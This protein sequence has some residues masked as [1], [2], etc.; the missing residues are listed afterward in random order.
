MPSELSWVDFSAEDRNSMLDVINLFKEQ[1][2]RDELGIGSIRDAFSDYFFP[3]TSTIQTRAKYMLFV[4]W[5]YKKLESSRV[6][7]SKI[8]KRARDEEIYL[9]Q[10]LKKNNQLD[11]LIGI[12]A[13][14][15][16]KRLPSNIYWSGLG[17]W[18]I[19]TFPANQENYHNYLTTYYQ[20]KSEIK[21]VH[22]E[23]D[24]TEHI[25][26]NWHPGMPTCP[27]G[28]PGNADFTL[29][30]EEA[31]YLRERIVTKHRTSLLAHLVFEK[32]IADVEHIWEYPVIK[33]ATEKLQAETIL[34]R[35]FSEAI[36]GAALLYNYMLADMKEDND[37]KEDFKNRLS[38]WSVL[39]SDRFDVFKNWASNM[40]K[41][42]SSEPLKYARIPERTKIFVEDWSKITI[43]ERKYKSLIDDSTTKNLIRNREFRLKRSRARLDN[44]RALELWS[45]DS[46]TSILDYRWRT[47]RTIVSDIVAG[48]NNT[49]ERH[50]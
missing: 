19:R 10:I 30:T 49:G 13:G 42:W 9:L 50:A 7:S 37:R 25:R 18:G 28:F 14:A 29:N 44:I 12:D 27:D 3:G 5:I 34:A 17:T 2:T 41:F 36:N 32:R 4:P 33:L 47:V 46:G 20:K 35:N 8:R 23:D 31:D 15:N 1:D 6:P 24:A 43:I 48:L 39:I 16:L 22:E 26:P 40:N 38:E 21:K 11:G 45:G